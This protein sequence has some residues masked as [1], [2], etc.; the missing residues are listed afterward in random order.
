MRVSAFATVRLIVM[1]R[2][3]W[4]SLERRNEIEQ[5][6]LAMEQDRMALEYP[7]WSQAGRKLPSNPRKAE[8][9]VADVA[10]WNKNYKAQ[11][12]EFEDDER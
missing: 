8:I 12:P 10:E 4:Q 5:T 6:R 1:L 11:H 7:K 2:R 3:I 9:T